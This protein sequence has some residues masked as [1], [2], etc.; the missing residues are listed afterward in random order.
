MGLQDRDYMREKRN[1]NPNK[2]FILKQKTHKG[3]PTKGKAPIMSS[4]TF[5]SIA[6]GGTILLLLISEGLKFIK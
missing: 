2:D 4:K 6:I 3:A 5:Y 1:N